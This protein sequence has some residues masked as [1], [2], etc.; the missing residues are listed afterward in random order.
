MQE[1]AE[2]QVQSMG[3]EGSLEKEMA[4]LSRILAWRIPWT[5]KPGELQSIGVTKSRTW[6]NQLSLYTWIE[7]LAEHI[8][9]ILL[10]V[11]LLDGLLS[12]EICFFFQL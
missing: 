1:T 5:G 12:C 9:A 10:N 6:L 3:R 11:Y 7:L 8:D 4:T 2:M